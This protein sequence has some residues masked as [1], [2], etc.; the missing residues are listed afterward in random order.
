VREVELD[1]ASWWEDMCFNKGPLISPRMFDEFM[2]PRY[3][4]I[5]DFLKQHGVTINIV[6]CDGNINELVPLWLKAGVNCMFPLEIAAGSKPEVLR[7]KY[8]REVLLMGGID[9][10]ALA[11][12][13]EAIDRELEKIPPLIEQGGYIPHVDHRVPPDVSYENYLYYIK[14]KREIIGV[15]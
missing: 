11:A 9:K 12:G 3:K 6:D 7:E 15:A 1:F 8:G 13:K 5:T 10:R 4:K 14:R 2:V